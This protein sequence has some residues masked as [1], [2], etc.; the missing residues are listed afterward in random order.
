LPGGFNRLAAAGGRQLIPSTGPARLGLEKAGVG[1]SVQPGTPR[2]R[3]RGPGLGVDSGVR[4]PSGRVRPGLV[5]AIWLVGLAS[6]FGE[7]LVSRCAAVVQGH[8]VVVEPVV[9]VQLGLLGRRQLAVRL[10]VGGLLDLQPLVGH[11]ELVAHLPGLG[12]R[13]KR[14]AQA[15]QA[16]PHHRPLGPIGLVVQV[17]VDN[18]ADLV[19]VAVDHDPAPPTTGRFDARGRHVGLL[20]RRHL[21]RAA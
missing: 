3:G 13:H 9:A 2:P 7:C 5:V 16:G 17:D 1:L 20:P 11:L 18:F 10:D 4:Q 19:V 6:R 12:E 21:S 14:R 8:G 15:E